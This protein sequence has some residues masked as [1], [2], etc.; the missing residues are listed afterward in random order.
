M[1]SGDSEGEDVRRR[2]LLLRGPGAGLAV[3]A[4]SSPAG[5][6]AGPAAGQPVTARPAVGMTDV[7]TV[8]AMTNTFRQLDS[9]FGG[10]HSRS[11]ANT[12]LTAIVEPMVHNGRYTD[13]VK[14]E[15]FSATADLHQV[16]GWMAYDTGQA[17]IGRSHLRDGLRLCQ[18]VEN[19]ALAAEMLAGMSYQAGF[20]G[21]AEGAVDLALAAQQAAKMR[22]IGP[23]L[24]R[25]AT[26]EAYGLALQG[27]KTGCMAALRKAEQEFAR[28]GYDVP[29]SLTHFDYAYLASMFAFAFR[30]LRL[31]EEAE[32]FARRS[33]EMADGNER[34]RLIRTAVLVGSLA[35]QGRVDEACAMAEHAV[36][37]AGTIRSTRIVVYLSDVA[38]RLAPFRA[39][40]EVRGLYERM[41]DAGIPVG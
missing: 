6:A 40:V 21:A 32:R 4:D 5:S 22:A 30:E 17:S 18:E 11:Q 14:V 8:R 33:L 41:A 25:A 2:E 38:R 13:T 16:I 15:L 34:G 24:S 35:D 28:R 20:A 39:A 27:D 36:D 1:S 19:D 31:P 3:I 9:E 10:G 37:M 29:P 7:E 26:M 12:Y 23:L